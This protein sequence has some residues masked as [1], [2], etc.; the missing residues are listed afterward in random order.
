MPAPWNYRRPG[1]RT[2]RNTRRGRYLANGRVRRYANQYRR[3]RMLS[4]PSTMLVK[5]LILPD[6]AFVKM[7]YTDTIAFSGAVVYDHRFRG[8][9]IFDP[10]YTGTGSQPTGRDQWFEFYSSY[11]VIGS[12]VEISMDNRSQY[13]ANFTVFPSNENLAVVGQDLPQT[14]PYMKNKFLAHDGNSQ[15][16]GKISTYMSTA[17]MYGKTPQAI[18][19]CEDFASSFSTDPQQQWFW[20]ICL[21]ST[22]D[23]TDAIADWTITITYYCKLFDR[24]NL[25]AS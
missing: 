22:D 16:L 10:D 5:P 15:T 23:S 7:S 11:C 3:R 21:Q 4:K 24:T 19:D 6:T 12:K 18:L 8:N 9:S 14:Y 13:A 20:H 2:Y 17:K 1:Y 25:S